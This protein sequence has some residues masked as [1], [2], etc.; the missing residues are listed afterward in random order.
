MKYLQKVMDALK[1]MQQGQPFNQIRYEQS[2][3]QRQVGSATTNCI[4]LAPGRILP[5]LTTPVHA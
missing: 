5:C 1:K 2:Q 3:N 4:E